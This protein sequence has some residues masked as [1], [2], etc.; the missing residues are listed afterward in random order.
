MVREP[1][2]VDATGQTKTLPKDAEFLHE[3]ESYWVEVWVSTSDEAG[4]GVAG[5]TVDLAYDTSRFTATQIKYGAAFPD[6]TTGTI[7]DAAGLIR[8]LGALTTQGGIGDVNDDG[9]IDR[10][11]GG[12]FASGVGAGGEWARLATVQYTATTDGQISF[13]LA[14]GDL[15]LSRFNLGNVSWDDVELGSLTLNATP[16]DLTGNG[17]VDFQDLTILLANWNQSVSAAQG[18][19]VDEGNTPVNFE[20]LTVLL[21]AWTGPGGAASPDAQQAV[22]QDPMNRVTTSA[23]VE[24]SSRAE[25]VQRRGK[26]AADARNPLR[27][28]QAAAV[29]RAMG[30]SDDEVVTRRSRRDQ[31]SRLYG[32]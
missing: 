25:R 31:R 17:F 26:P 6:Q 7:D 20:D 19:L 32:R 12:T 11:G 14:E 15:H 4:V 5:G 22:R 1:T 21:A 10:L 24:T 16:A 9:L 13:S 23:S 30:E 28:L 8:N 29:D 2:N 18:N 3:W 27:R